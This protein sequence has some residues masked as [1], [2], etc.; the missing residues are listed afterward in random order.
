ML[1]IPDYFSAPHGEAFQRALPTLRRRVCSIPFAQRSG[2]CGVGGN[3]LR[4]YRRWPQRPSS[5]YRE[6]ARGVCDTL[7]AQLLCEQVVTAEGFRGWHASLADSL[8][9]HWIAQ[10]GKALS[11]AHQHKLID[12]FIKWLSGH[13]FGCA[14]LT[15]AFVS[16]G[17]CALDSQ[18]LDKLNECLS[19]ALP[20]TNPSMGDIHTRQTY[21]FCQ[22]LIGSFAHHYGGTRLLFDYFAWNP[23]GHPA[24]SS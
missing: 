5:V 7:D 23:G 15:D 6:W 4:A 9:V 19:W 10:Q 11:F 20:L 24:R 22:S 17:N 1:S 2:D 14:Q 3:T 18:T 13:D 8:Q 16:H 12:L 21:E